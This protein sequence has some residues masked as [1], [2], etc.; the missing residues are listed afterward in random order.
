MLVAGI[1]DNIDRDAE[2]VAENPEL[3][4]KLHHSSYSS[5]DENE[6]VDCCLI[7]SPITSSPL[8]RL[9]PSLM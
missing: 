1:E 5:S 6:R 2:V 8:I 3:V 4:E 9:Y 7:I